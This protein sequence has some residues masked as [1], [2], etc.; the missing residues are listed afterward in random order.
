MLILQVNAEQWL[1]NEKAQLSLLVPSWVPT[2]IPLT[3]PLPTAM[4]AEA[5]QAVSCDADGE[6]GECT[7]P[8]VLHAPPKQS[9]NEATSALSRQYK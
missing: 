7:L 8:E 5:D 1:S 6:E 4:T 2:K 3:A 9:L